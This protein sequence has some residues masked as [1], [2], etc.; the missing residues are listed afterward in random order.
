MANVF[1]RFTVLEYITLFMYA[2]AVAAPLLR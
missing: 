2:C 1:E